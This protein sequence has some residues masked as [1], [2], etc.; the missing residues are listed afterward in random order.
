[1]KQNRQKL[2]DLLTYKAEG[3][4]RYTSR[5]YYEFGNRASQL[6]AFQLRKAQSSRAVLKIKHP[7]TGITTSQPKEIAEAFKDYY[8]KLYEKDEQ[9]NKEEKIKTFLDSVKLNRLTGEESEVM[10]SPITEEEIKRNI[11]KLKNSKSPGVDGFPGEFYKAFINELTPILCTGYRPISLLCQDLKI[12][13]SILAERIQTHIRKLVKPEP[14]Q[15]GFISGRHG[16]D[17]VRRALNIQTIAG[18]R[19]VHSMLLSLDAEKAFDWTYLK[20]T[21]A[22]MGFHDT[23]IRWIQ[24]FYHNPKSRVRV[25]GH[26]SEFFDLGRGTRQGDAMSPVLFALSIEPLA[27]SIICNHHIQGIADESGNCQKIALYA[28]DILLFIE[29]PISSIPAVLDC[30]E[31]YESISGYKINSTKSEALMI[32][33]V[34]PIE[35][36]DRASFR[37]SKQGFKYLRVAITP[38]VSQLYQANYD[39]LIHN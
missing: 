30:L 36:N 1:M 8:N 10:V 22:H 35:L 14:D 27:E 17:N 6:L 28:D 37:W 4:L 21:L 9:P 33:G 19:K 20:Q 25:N 7:C 5:K 39:K 18:K 38:K 24:I 16:T 26:C 32:T 12:L 11:G 31:V 15:T 34:W 2:D 29:N 3:A 23:F 13:T